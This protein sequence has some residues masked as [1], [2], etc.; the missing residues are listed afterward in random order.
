MFSWYLLGSVLDIS[1][2]LYFSAS[3]TVLYV[4]FRHVLVRSWSDD[5]LCIFQSFI[6]VYLVDPLVLDMRTCFDFSE[7]GYARL[8][9][10]F[11]LIFFCG[12][13]GWILVK[14]S[15][16][17]GRFPFHVLSQYIS[18]IM[19]PFWPHI[20]GGICYSSKSHY[21]GLWCCTHGLGQP[22]LPDLVSNLK[23][24]VFYSLYATFPWVKRVYTRVHIYP[25]RVYVLKHLKK[26]KTPYFQP[27][28][29][30]FTCWSPVS[31]RGLNCPKPIPN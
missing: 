27:E 15:S 22:L 6:L 30:G 4:I 20:L 2:P 10:C 29:A 25:N 17:F 3:L 24:T 7:H 18:A 28:I 11:F 14:Y 1:D 26:Y 12:L 9:R 5:P 21:Y 8:R 31:A 16:A 13:A 23:K 19:Y